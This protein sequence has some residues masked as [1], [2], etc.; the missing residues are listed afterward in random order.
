MSS[1]RQ[2][3]MFGSVLCRNSGAEPN[4]STR[5]PTEPKRL[6]SASRIDASSSMTKTTGPFALARARGDAGRPVTLHPLDLLAGCRERP[7]HAA[8]L[9]PPIHA[10][11]EPR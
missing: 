3:A 4:T 7:P 10:L 1:T 5:K 8:H 6:L 2:L 11:R 9:A